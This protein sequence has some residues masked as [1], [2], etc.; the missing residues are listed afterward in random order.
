MEGGR[1]GWDDWGTGFTRG[2][3]RVWCLGA[4]RMEMVFISARSNI[5]KLSVAASAPRCG[6]L[7]SDHANFTIVW[8]DS[9]VCSVVVPALA[10]GPQDNVVIC[11]K[12]AFQ[13]LF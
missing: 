7:S 12:T 5:F 3:G 10:G 2:R 8:C 1:E 9:G 4:T 11:E 13:V 6:E